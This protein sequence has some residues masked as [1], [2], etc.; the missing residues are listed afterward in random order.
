ML[1][2]RP[3]VAIV[4]ASTK[5]FFG[6]VVRWADNS[7]INHAMVVYEDRLWSGFSKAEAT[8]LEGVEMRPFDPDDPYY[9][10]LE[11]FIYQGDITPGLQMVKKY[12]GAGYDYVGATSGIFRMVFRKLFGL[13]SAVPIQDHERLFCF[14]FVIELL[15]SAQVPG[16]AELIPGDTSP[17]TIREWLMRHEYFRKI[18]VER[19]MEKTDEFPLVMRGCDV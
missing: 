17:A 16:A 4:L 18:S 7:K 10:K 1:H 5:G 6:R 9:L 2:H 13:E 8:F 15:Q 14:E 11:F 3:K 19:F 12:L